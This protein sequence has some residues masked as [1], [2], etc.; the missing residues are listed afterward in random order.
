M[1]QQIAYHAFTKSNTP[2]EVE[3]F[4]RLWQLSKSAA[5]NIN[6]WKSL[7]ANLEQDNRESHFNLSILESQLELN[8]MDPQYSN[9][10]I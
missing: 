1:I 5:R 3:S 8:E 2:K 4:T 6:E 7:L 9:E 10:Q